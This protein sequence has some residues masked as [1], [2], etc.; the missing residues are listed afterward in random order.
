MGKVEYSLS[1]CA[2]I[3]SSLLEGARNYR[4]SS[5]RCW[6]LS[7]PRSV[8]FIKPAYLLSPEWKKQHAAIIAP[9]SNCIGPE[10][11]VEY[12][13]RLMPNL[14]AAIDDFQNPRV[15]AH[16]TSAV[17]NFSENCSPDIL[18]PYL[19]GI[20]QLLIHHRNKKAL[21]LWTRPIDFIRRFPSIF[22]E[23]LPGGI[24]IHPHVRL[25][26]QVLNLD[27]EELSIFQTENYRKQATDQLL[28]LLML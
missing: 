21:D 4:E 15:Q 24:R 28:K 3:F 25:T 14:A 9:C 1:E 7:E 10:L 2:S 16:A 5:V 23:F 17:L 13:Q 11:Q 22:E 8:K 12:H 26:P 6:L 27:G 19:I 20:H 18:T